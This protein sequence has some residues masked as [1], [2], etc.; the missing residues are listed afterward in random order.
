MGK[1]EVIF[2]TN[3]M[4]ETQETRNNGIWNRLFESHPLEARKDGRY[5]RERMPICGGGGKK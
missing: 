3:S 2:K 5:W 1:D 4:T